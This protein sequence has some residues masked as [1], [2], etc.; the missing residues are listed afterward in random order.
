MTQVTIKTDQ[1]LKVFL[2]KNY[3]AQIK[4]FF[5]EEQQAMKFLSSV[6]AD[7]QKNPQLLA[8]DQVTLINSYMTMA[9]LGLMPSGVSGEAYVLPY[10]GK[11]QFQ[12]GY[13]GLITLFYRAGGTGIRA[14]LVRANDKFEYTNGEIKHTID[15]FKSNAER[16]EVVGAYAIANVNGQEI[17]KA[18]NI[19]DIK[20]FGK[21][22]S[23]SYSSEFSPWN[24]KN[25]PEGWM[26]KKTVL[27][28]LAKMLP[29]NETI[30]KAF[31][32]DNQDSRI[33][34]VKAKVDNNNLSMGN[35]LTN[36][37]NDK[38]KKG[39]EEGENQQDPADGDKV[40]DADK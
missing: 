36:N 16:G 33:A 38:N 8:C 27:K 7:V 34:D 19:K 28:Q 26:Y 1:D 13:Q 40:I 29:K 17:S 35:F 5:G 39:S 25:D 15:I 37:K 3:L 2:A 10:K 4:N 31:E 9:Q 24:E 18:M 23:K 6:M 14:E 11:A 32:A 21:N 20:D 12:L 22:F 30:N